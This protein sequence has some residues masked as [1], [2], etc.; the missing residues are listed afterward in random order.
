MHPNV[1]DFQVEVFSQ[2]EVWHLQEK[3]EDTVAEVDWM[4]WKLGEDRILLGWTEGIVRWQRSEVFI[5][6]QIKHKN[7]LLFDEGL[8]KCM[9]Y[10]AKKTHSTCSGILVLKSVS[11]IDVHIC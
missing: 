9:C 6:P 11:I 3:Q 4:K 5:D 7:T 1:Q 10:N 8:F 2:K